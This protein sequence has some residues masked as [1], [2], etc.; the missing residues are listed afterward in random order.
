MEAVII[1]QLE[2]VARDGAR[3]FVRSWEPPEA[4]GTILL[5][6]G[7]GEHSGRYNHVAE[8][9]TATGVRV[10]TWDLRGH[11]R[12]A[13][14]RGD[15]EGYEMLVDDLQEI[16]T[17]AAA[18]PRP[19]FL[20]GHSLGGQITLNFAVRHRP[21]AAGLVIT[22]PWFRL[23]F[24]AP[25]WKVSLAWIAARLWPSFTQD[26]DVM[27]SRLSRDLDFLMAM[28]D[29]DLIHH[30]M[31]AR[32]YHALTDGA[33]RAA[34]EAVALPYPILLIHGDRDPVTS[35]DATKEF[36]HALRSVDKSLVIIPE[37]LHET[38]N[39]LCR[40]NVLD[41]ITEWIEARLPAL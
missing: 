36:F 39:D 15:I 24:T 17:L 30:R 34:R 21:E 8:R 19:V 26:T 3:L 22:S 18:G 40:E 33:V 10:V 27:P 2:H 35:V 11:G 23:A 37:A 25:R 28:P 31:S 6:H 12:S 20:Y 41:R 13:G 9:L 7:M 5:T 38:H 32:M 4:R 1:H 14:E 29:M 16:W